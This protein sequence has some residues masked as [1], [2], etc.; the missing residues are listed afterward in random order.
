MTLLRDSARPLL[1]KRVAFVFGPGNIG[2]DYAAALVRGPERA[3]LELGADVRTFNLALLK[4]AI[5]QFEATRPDPARDRYPETSSLVREL[6]AFFRQ[7][8]PFD[9]TLGFFYDVCLAAP[10]EEAL[11]T[12]GGHLV[13]YPLNLLDQ[14]GHFAR[15]VELFDETF[16]AEEDALP[17]LGAK[18]RYVPMASDPWIF[19]PLGPA[20][21]EPRL[22]FVGSAYGPRHEALARCAQVIDTTALGSRFGLQGT[23]RA[24]GR[25]VVR[26]RRLPSLLPLREAL[27][28][29]RRPIGDEAF[30]RLAAAHGV[31]VGFSDVRQE[32]TGALLHKVRLREYDATMSGLCHLARRLPELERHFEP[33]RELLL[34][35]S[36]DELPD[37]LARIRRGELDWRAIGAAARRRAAR[38]HTWTQRLRAAFQS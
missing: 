31:S 15:A 7:E 3:L 16:C 5:V 9:L 26:E 4:D 25:A 22:L 35:D 20:P 8:G 29:D 38:D 23:M 2:V 28:R 13:N 34:Y 17:A 21:R 1:G 30:V 6:A 36:L 18:G 32:G 12:H 10:V 27:L 11:R 37:L 14:P 33:G 19:R 24:L